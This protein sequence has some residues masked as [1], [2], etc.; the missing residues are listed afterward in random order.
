[1]L[2]SKLIEVLLTGVGIADPDTE[3]GAPAPADTLPLRGL[4][5]SA[6]SDTLRDPVGLALL[7]ES[8]LGERAALLREE[9][10]GGCCA[11]AEGR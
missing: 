9:G 4:I 1:M 5:A 8:V 6:E 3:R 2:P 10:R 11:D 7:G